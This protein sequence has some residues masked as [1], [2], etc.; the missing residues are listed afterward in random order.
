M[1]GLCRVLAPSLQEA[2]DAVQ[3]TFLAAYRSLLKGNEPRHPAAWLATIARNE[4]WAQ[5][6]RRKREPVA[7]DGND[8]E[9]RLPDPVAAA[10]AR[11]DLAELC[12]AIGDLP[13]QQ[14]QA[15][16]LREF[17]GLSYEELADALA[18]SEPAVES[19]LVRAR[20][21]VRLRVRPAFRTSAVVIPLVGGR[22]SP[23]RLIEGGLPMSDSGGSGLAKLAAG[24]AAVVVAGGTVAA[25]D[26]LSVH[27]R[28]AVRPTPVA[29][30]APTQAR[31][32]P[33]RARRHDPVTVTA[34]TPPRAAVATAYQAPA[35]A[36][37]PSSSVTR[38]R[39]STVPPT[40]R[41]P[42]PASAAVVT[43]DGDVARPAVGEQPTDTASTP[44]AAPVDP[45][46]APAT[47]PSPGGMPGDG[48]TVAPAT[49]GSSTGSDGG[50]GETV[51]PDDSVYDTTDVT[52]SES[53]QA[54]SVEGGDG[55]HSDSHDGGGG[56]S[57]PGGDD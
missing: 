17:S 44:D 20:R 23:W 54:D 29:A 3:Q 43:H 35:V 47:E 36:S 13:Q 34:T 51:A 4:C 16:L 45:G 37:A 33:A 5:A 55:G 40:T 25:V 18:V 2:E 56:D 1:L 49:D 9:S 39:A 7:E 19:L 53:D 48:D 30:S 42:S 32:A 24:A 26:T 6:R 31:V 46:P 10:A 38:T 57:G 15:F 11:A 22:L 12:R 8:A 50:G 14:R 52:T 27:D 21:Q 41:R 28:A